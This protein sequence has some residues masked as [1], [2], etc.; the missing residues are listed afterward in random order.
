MVTLS[1]RYTSGCYHTRNRYLVDRCDKLLAL[2]NGGGKGGTAYTVQYA[3]QR[4]KGIVVID[5]IAVE[6]RMIP[7]RLA[8]AR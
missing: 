4:N 5:P 8:S 7:P 2:Y 3:R 6:R 1:S